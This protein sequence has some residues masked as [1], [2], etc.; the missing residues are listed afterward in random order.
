MT[1]RIY[2]AAVMALTGLGVIGLNLASA[3]TALTRAKTVKEVMEALNKG[4]KSEGAKLK[5]ALAAKTPNWDA[6]QA[7]TTQYAD[8]GPQLGENDPPKG[9]KES[10]Q[11]H[12]ETFAAQTKAL[13]AAADQ[14]DLAATKTAFQK[15]SMSCMGCHRAHRPMK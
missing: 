15:I 2:C 5:A 13:G 12:S 14:K 3:G 7:S 1:R 4:P 11:T 9:N 8:L 10:W 6:I